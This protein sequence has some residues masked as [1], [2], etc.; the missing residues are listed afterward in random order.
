M[1]ADLLEALRVGTASRHTQLD[2]AVSGYPIS[3]RSG[4]ERFLRLQATVLPAVEAWL[5][6]QPL[7]R[8]LPDFDARLRTGV[9]I[10]DMETLGLP[11]PLGSGGTRLDDGMS[12]VGICYVLEGSRLG[13]VS[14]NSMLDQSGADVPRAFLNHGKGERYWRSFLQ[15]MAERDRSTQAVD[16][17]VTAAQELFD[18]YLAAA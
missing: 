6:H 7:Y 17:A 2:R 12:V 16:E 10:N 18:A 13:A 3:T 1:P 4:Y 9:L 8:T 15:W 14:L 5:V 11:R